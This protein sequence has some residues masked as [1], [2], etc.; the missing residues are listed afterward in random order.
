MKNKKINL[1]KFEKLNSEQLKKVI[2]GDGGNGIDKDKI[3]IK[4]VRKR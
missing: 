2:G 3:K 4:S 1:G